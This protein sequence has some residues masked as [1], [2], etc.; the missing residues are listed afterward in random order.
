MPLC[1]AAIG[2]KT[3]VGVKL[4]SRYRVRGKKGQIE[5]TTMCELRPS[6]IKRCRALLGCFISGSKIVG[7]YS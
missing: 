2:Y 7:I 4:L 1:E 6:R 5:L 3:Y